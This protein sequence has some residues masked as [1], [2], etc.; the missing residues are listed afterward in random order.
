[1]SLMFTQQP[2]AVRWLPCG[3]FV[4]KSEI[5]TVLNCNHVKIIII[6]I[7][8]IINLALFV[9]KVSLN[10]NSSFVCEKM[11]DIITKICTIA[12]V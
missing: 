5:V 11:L 8:I 10:R 3:L 9:E 1:M 6:I 7:I 4:F 12:I 2:N